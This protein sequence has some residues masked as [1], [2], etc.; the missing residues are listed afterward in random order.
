VTLNVLAARLGQ[1]ALAGAGIA[2]ASALS[3]TAVA[4]AIHWLHADGKLS[5]FEPV[6]GR[7]G[8]SVATS[9][10]SCSIHGEIV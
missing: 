7:P 1:R 9:V 4:R 3:F 2:P 10:G 8:F 5:Y 6:A